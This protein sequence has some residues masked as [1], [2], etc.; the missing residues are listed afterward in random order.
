VHG[1]LL[2]IGREMGATEIP[3]CPEAVASDVREDLAA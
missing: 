3:F 2:D 1:Q